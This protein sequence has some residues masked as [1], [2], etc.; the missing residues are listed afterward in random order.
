MKIGI[1]GSIWI[2][3]PPK[4][5]GFGAQ[6]YLVYQIA[7]GLV[8]RGHEVTLFASGDSVTNA[9]LASV[10]PHQAID[11]GYPGFEKETFELMNLQEAY[12]KTQEFDI[13]HNHLLPLGLLFTPF[14]KTPTLHTLHHEI[15]K[16]KPDKFLYDKF[17]DQNFVAISNSQKKIRP[18]LNYVGTIYNGVDQNYYEFLDKPNG[19]YLLFLGRLK[20]YKGIDI[21]IDICRKLDLELKVAAPPPAI[22]QPDYE[23]V[24]AY[25]Q[26]IKKKIGGKIEFLGEVVGEGKQHLIRNAK[27]LLFPVQ[28]DEPF[29]MTLIE[30]MSCGTPVVAYDRGATSEII[31]DLENGFLVKAEK[32]EDSQF[33]K[34]LKLALSLDE[35]AYLAMRKNARKRVEE[36]FTAD[37][38]VENYIEIYNKLLI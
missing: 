20:R 3:I 30:A 6:E 7:E 32:E 24:A 28:R 35:D 11:L 38:M 33:M 2:S 23:E 27:Y 31:T 25:W 18:D 12:K 5:F 22:G 4:Q 29:G 10:L 37:R 34:V 21:A 13:L 8:K 26:E 16:D 15:K 17:K 14:S 1:V 19:N 36:K 9:K